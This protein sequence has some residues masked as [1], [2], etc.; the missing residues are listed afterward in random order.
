MRRLSS[1]SER[2]FKFILYDT[3]YSLHQRGLDCGDLNYFF[4]KMRQSATKF[5]GKSV[6]FSASHEMQEL[7]TMA[8]P[9]FS[10]HSDLLRF[11]G[12]KC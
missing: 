6:L 8:V 9:G 10:I 3:E 4:V 1:T 12:P 7:E 5:S 11:P 2:H